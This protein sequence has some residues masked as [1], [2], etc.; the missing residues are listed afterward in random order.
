M[1][2]RIENPVLLP[3]TL[4][5]L[6]QVLLAENEL[7]GA[8]AAFDESLRQYDDLGDSSGVARAL[9]RSPRL[10][11]WKSNPTGMAAYWRCRTITLDLH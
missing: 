9:K 8:R 7:A 2:R 11:S 1:Q 5:G 3:P 10:R 4:V 6:G